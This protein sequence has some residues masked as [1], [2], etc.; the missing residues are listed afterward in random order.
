MS[1]HRARRKI[2][3]ELL[4]WGV[5]EARMVERLLAPQPGERLLEVGSSAGYRIEEHAGRGV[6]L[7]G[8]DADNEAIK[9]GKES[10]VSVNLIEGNAEDL[11][12]HDGFFDKVLCV[13]LLEHL[14][15][16]HRAIAQM[17][18]VL[19]PDGQ[20]IIVVPCE[21]IRGD[22][23]FAGW[24]KFKNL[25]LHRFSPPQITSM[26]QPYFS[27]VKALFHTF[28]PGQFK[29]MPLDTTPLLYYFSLAMVFKVRKR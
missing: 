23:A 5:A 17:A 11:P 26:L 24:L 16:P 12:Y 10:G 18:R 27:I 19:K 8:I 2:G 29:P 9:A 25:H 14:A 22:T 4:P 7:W 6:E 13:H 21:R 1:I 20:A 3:V 15:E 28:I